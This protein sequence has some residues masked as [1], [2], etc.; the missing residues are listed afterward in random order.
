MQSWTKDQVESI[1]LT[2]EET[3]FPLV[4]DS[5]SIVVYLQD[6]STGEILQAA[7]IP[8]YSTVS[9]FDVP[10]PR[11]RVL[12]YPNPAS[13]LVNIYFEDIPEEAML[14]RLYDLSGKI[15]L[16]DIIEPWQQRYTRSLSDLGEGLYIVEIRSRR[17]HH[18]IQRDKLFH[19]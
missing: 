12:L 14:L 5:L 13:D 10:E 6:E 9:T 1:L 3:F 4:E 7:T 2:C 16:T 19:Y 11:S 15:V 18:V 8:E 17:N